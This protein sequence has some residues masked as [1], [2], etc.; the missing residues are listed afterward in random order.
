[1]KGLGAKP[2]LTNQVLSSINNETHILLGDLDDMADRK[3]SEEVSKILPNAKFTLL[4]E[5]P[6]P[7]EKVGLSPIVSLF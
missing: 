6:H 3:F 5:T 7:I 2:L 4:S 1:M